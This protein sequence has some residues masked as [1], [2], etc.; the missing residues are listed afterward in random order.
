[1]A[2]F[3]FLNEFVLIT[4]S[5]LLSLMHFKHLPIKMSLLYLDV[6]CS[7]RNRSLLS[8]FEI[9]HKFH[10]NVVNYVSTAHTIY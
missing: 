3:A 1:M 2:L 4:F 8:A 5:L 10:L 6:V 7:Q 9:A